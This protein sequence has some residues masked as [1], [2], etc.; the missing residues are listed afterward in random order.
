[1]GAE[2]HRLFQDAFGD[3]GTDAAAHV[4]G[5]DLGDHAVLDVVNKGQ[6][7]VEQRAGVDGNV[8]ISHAGDLVHDH[9]QHI[10]A[11]SQMVVEGD[12][13]AVLDACQLN[14]FL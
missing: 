4:V 3:L 14:G 5:D 10:V 2:L 1:M 8:L 12:A 13:A 7:A 9:V 11:V 6:M